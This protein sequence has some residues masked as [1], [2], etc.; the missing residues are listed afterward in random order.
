MGSPPFETEST[1][2]T[3]DRIK[4][5]D[6]NFPPSVPK[7]AADLISRVRIFFILYIKARF[8]V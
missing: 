1:E 6:L 5:V 3:Y 7:G 4:S 2:R 8:K